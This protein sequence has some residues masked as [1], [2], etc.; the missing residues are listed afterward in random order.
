MSSQ[1]A[2]TQGGNGLGMPAAEGPVDFSG[3]A[4]TINSLALN[5]I[6][7]KVTAGL[8]ENAGSHT[9]A[10]TAEALIPCQGAL[11]R[12]TASS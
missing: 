11:L 7:S 6:D 8:A 5:L 1:T 2:L 9:F 3:E 12:K 4:A 10:A